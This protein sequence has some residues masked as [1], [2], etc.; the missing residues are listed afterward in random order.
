MS[1]RER[2]RPEPTRL[3]WDVEA[4]EM[5]CEGCGSLLMWDFG[6]ETCPYCH[7]PFSEKEAR[8]ARAD[9]RVGTAA[10]SVRK[11]VN[12][13]RKTTETRR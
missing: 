10:M 1:R 4:E 6:F 9:V 12:M 8:Q 3:V 7:R 13:R 11:T 5:M 2:S